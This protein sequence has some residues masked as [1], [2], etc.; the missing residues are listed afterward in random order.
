MAL[1]R[2][3]KYPGAK[4]VLIPEI[5][6]VFRLSGLRMMVDVFGGSG[7]VSLNVKAETNVYNDYEI[8]LAE[9]FRA[10]QEKP[11]ETRKLLS[12]ILRY[13]QQPHASAGKRQSTGQGS[14]NQSNR[15]LIE[16][17]EGWESH[18]QSIPNVVHKSIDLKVGLPTIE[19]RS[20][21]TIYKFSS[22]FGGM[23]KTYAT[24][25]EKSVQRFISKTLENFAAIENRVR[26]WKIENMDFRD[27]MKKYDSPEAFFYLDPPYV[28][29]QW[30]NYNF[31]KADFEDVKSVIGGLKGKF[32]MNLNLDV[33]YFREIFGNPTFVRYYPDNNSRYG[34]GNRSRGRAFYTNVDLLT[35][36]RA[37]RTDIKGNL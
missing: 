21:F 30:Y 17:I 11:D 10:I 34:R 9:M 32:L 20:V 3:I 19:E 27:L 5:Y 24:T 2:L 22:S 15:R 4:N 28:G 37:K 18:R 7:S 33:D 16:H 8:E 35:S 23:G 36:V 13:L 6:R 31:T 14:G 25:R 12:Q 29:K 26:R 1:L